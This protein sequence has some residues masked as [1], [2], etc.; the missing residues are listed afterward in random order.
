MSRRSPAR[1]QMVVATCALALC[2][3]ACSGPSGTR[4]SVSASPGAP[5]SAQ[6]SGV[7]TSADSGHWLSGQWLR[8]EPLAREIWSEVAGQ[9]VG[10]GFAGT[11]QETRW[12][13]VM[14][15]RDPGGRAVLTAMPAGRSLVDFPLEQ[16]TERGLVFANLAHEGRRIGYRRQG[17]E[18]QVRV[19]H[20]GGVESFVMR[21]EAH[22]PAPDLVALDRSF[23]DD[24]SGRDGAAWAAR[25]EDL[26]V[27]WPRGG[28]RTEGREAIA[29][30]LARSV[31]RRV[32]LDWQPLTSGRSPAGDMGFTSGRYRAVYKQTGERLSSGVYVT[33]WRRHG[34]HWRI[35]FNTSWPDPR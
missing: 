35:A 18:L 15:I 28:P 30:A 31:T 21:G 11:E 26:G 24:S 20:T 23:V 32:I 22:A 1:G 10:I 27:D 7:G 29:Q 25:F 5:V 9:L 12:F 3:L 6:V 19:E 4:A 13:E 33:I 16:Q 8:E 17:E 2:A 34:E 14:F